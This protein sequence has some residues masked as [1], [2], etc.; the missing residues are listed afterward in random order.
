[1]LRRR[2]FSRRAGAAP[3]QHG[4]PDCCAARQTN[5]QATFALGAAAPLLTCLGRMAWWPQEAAHETAR[6]IATQLRSISQALVAAVALPTV[7][8]ATLPQHACAPHACTPAAISQCTTRCECSCTH[9]C[10]CMCSLLSCGGGCQ[11]SEDGA[12]GFQGSHPVATGPDQARWQLHRSVRTRI[13]PAGGACC[14]RA[15]RIII[16]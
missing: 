8:R 12:A 4:R 13:G 5:L 6:I 1:M 7:F 16:A 11:P 14:A 2:F 3:V 10:M 9:L 15:P